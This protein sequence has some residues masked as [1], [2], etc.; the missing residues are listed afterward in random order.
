MRRIVI[1]LAAVAA[2]AGALAGCGK[3]R[4]KHAE[5]SRSAA[6]RGCARDG[7][8]RFIHPNV[9]WGGS[10]GDQQRLYVVGQCRDGRAF[11]VEPKGVKY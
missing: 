11:Q 6:T 5:S 2:L 7:G 8:P 4:L 10:S 3:N 1:A 9:F